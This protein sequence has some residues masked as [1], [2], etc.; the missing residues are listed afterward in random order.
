[1][2]L[3]PFEQ[4]VDRYEQW[5]EENPTAYQAEL[6]AVAR[7]LPCSGVGVEIG[8]GTGRF[9]GP[10][11]IRLGLEPSAAMSEVAR[12]RGID[13]SAGVA[14][15][16][17]WAE[18]S[19][20]FALMV[21]TLCFLT[22]PQ[23]SLR[24]AFRIL[25]P[26]GSLIVGFLDASSPL[27]REYRRRQAASDFYRAARLYSAVEVLRLFASAR[28]QDLTVVQTLFEHETVPRTPDPTVPG[29]GHGLFVV[30]RGTKPTSSSHP[31]PTTAAS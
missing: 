31:S 5:F 4:Y 22:D 1:M 11:G 19:F 8:V 3:N 21:T 6:R 25:K 12:R 2:T 29:H 18:A 23:A 13:V 16:L 14:E 30:V 26:G 27:G 17:L 10:L 15:R 28:F 24:E 7:L 20:D 9:A